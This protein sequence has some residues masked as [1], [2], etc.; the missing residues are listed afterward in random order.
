[1]KM[2]WKINGEFFSDAIP[3]VRSEVYGF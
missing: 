2:Q 3:E 1:M